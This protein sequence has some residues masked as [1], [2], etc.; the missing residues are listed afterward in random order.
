MATK[1]SNSKTLNSLGYKEKKIS[2]PMSAKDY[3][4]CTPLLQHLLDANK[5]D[6]HVYDETTSTVHVSRCKTV[7]KEKRFGDTYPERV[8]EVPMS[9][10]DYETCTTGTGLLQQIAFAGV[11]HAYVY[12]EETKAAYLYYK[13]GVEEGSLEGKGEDLQAEEPKI[14]Q[15]RS[16]R[17]RIMK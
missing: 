5:I 1:A 3:D 6:S 10:E 8:L 13:V 7:A 17:E 2:V 16:E 15:R 11:I 4:I 14:M 9:G 12:G